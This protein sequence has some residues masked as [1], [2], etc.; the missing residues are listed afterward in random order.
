[1]SSPAFR[2]CALIPTYDNPLTIA[3]V[4][5]EARRHLEDV[6]IVDDGSGPAGRA[7]VEA[8]AR[9]GAATVTH[10]PR[11]GGKG[12][13]VKTGF[14]A[15][16]AAGFTHALQIDADGQHDPTDIPTLLALAA[17]RPEAAVL[18]HPVFDDSTP[19]GR[20]AAHGLTNFW[21]RLETGGRAIVDPQCG[22]RVYPLEPALGVGAVGNHMEFDIEIA[23]RL[24]WAGVPII[25]VPTRVRYLPATAGGVSHF[26]PVGDNVAITLMHTRLVLGSIRWRLRRLLA[27]RRR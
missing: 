2:P 3:A 25:N 11:N 27:R 5:A 16:H 1:M 10:R 26:R 8:L 13:A 22:F 24:V 20:R 12:A 9:Q 17:Q 21:T 4:V 14:A 23:V 18:G 7:A 15:A 19:R 6:L